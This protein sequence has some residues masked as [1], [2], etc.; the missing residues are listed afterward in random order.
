MP[1]SC[2]CQFAP[3][4]QEVRAICKTR[5]QLSLLCPIWK[6][7]S[8]SIY[9]ISQAFLLA[10]ELTFHHARRIFTYIHPAQRRYDEC[11]A[12]P[13]AC[14]K[15]SLGARHMVLTVGSG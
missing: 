12:T 6:P 9:L 8:K 7:C 15:V 14:V 4:L 11:V 10:I 2:M 1:S 13:L 5:N 3:R